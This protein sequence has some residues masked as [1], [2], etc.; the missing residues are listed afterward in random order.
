M[1]EKELEHSY[2]RYIEYLESKGQIDEAIQCCTRALD[3][4][5]GFLKIDLIEK[6]GDLRHACGDNNESLSLYIK[7]F[8]GRPEEEL[9]EKITHLSNELGLWKNVKKELTSFNMAEGGDTH[10][11]LELYLRDKDFF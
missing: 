4:A 5:K 9:L 1:C 7:S 2:F 3:F 10:N 8:K 6:M 11:L